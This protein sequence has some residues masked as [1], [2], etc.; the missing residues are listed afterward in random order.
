MYNK[1]IKKYLNSRNSVLKYLNIVNNSNC[2]IDIKSGRYLIDGKSVM[3]VFSIDISSELDIR[4][5]GDSELEV[6]SL[7]QAIEGID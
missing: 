2:N 7:V 6:D 5:Y 1:C 4:I 3:G